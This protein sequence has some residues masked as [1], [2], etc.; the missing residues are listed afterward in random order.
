MLLQLL[1]AMSSVTKA[2]LLFPLFEVSTNHH[3]SLETNNHNAVFNRV[4][5]IMLIQTNEFGNETKLRV[6][7]GVEW[8]ISSCSFNSI[9]SKVII[10]KRLSLGQ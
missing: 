8:D 5:R 2:G 1:S 6:S 4:V 3:F 10:P 7:T 9:E